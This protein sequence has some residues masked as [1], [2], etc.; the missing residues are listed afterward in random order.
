[1]H[2][3]FEPNPHNHLSLELIHL[4]QNLGPPQRIEKNSFQS[5]NFE[6]VANILC[7]LVQIVDSTIP[8]HNGIRT[9]DDRVQFLNGITSELASRLH[10]SLDGRKLYAANGYAVQELVKLAQFIRIAIE[11]VDEE[12]NSNGN[13]TLSTP[14]ETS[15]TDV[16]SLAN[17]LSEMGSDIQKLLKQEVND[18]VARA[19]ALEF[20]KAVTENSSSVEYDGIETNLRQRLDET[21]DSIDRL[22]KQIK[23]LISTNKGMEEK[24]RKRSIDIERGTKRLES[25]DL[26]NVRPSYMDEYEQIEKELQIEYDRWMV[27]FRNVDYLEA[28]LRKRRTAE[29]IKSKEAERSV[30]RLQKKYRDEE[31]R[32][33]EGSD[34]SSCEKENS[35]PAEN[36]S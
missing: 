35:R 22:D 36:I 26:Q 14:S 18:S 2:L 5:P 32:V 7:Y 4:L 3:N 16:Q 6:L 33:L 12:S 10:L 34:G 17:E 23:M 15:V 24:I 31:L 11:L 20:L 27:R 19:D 29:T 30:K 1:M 28:E 8:I 9:E 13:C 25:L 21:N